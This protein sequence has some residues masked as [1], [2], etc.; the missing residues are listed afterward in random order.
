MRMAEYMIRNDTDQLMNLVS[1]KEA[2]EKIAAEAKDGKLKAEAV[3]RLGGY[4]CSSC[5]KLNPPGEDLTCSC[6]FCGAENH[7]YV[8]VDNIQEYRDY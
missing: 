3:R 1:D 5:G 7:D 8:H 4:L 2:L 6:R